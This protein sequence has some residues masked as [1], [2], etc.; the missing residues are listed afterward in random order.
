M[1]EAERLAA[2]IRTEAARLRGVLAEFQIAAAAVTPPRSLRNFSDELAALGETSKRFRSALIALP[3]PDA[4]TRQAML[5]ARDEYDAVASQ[6]LT[7]AEKMMAAARAAR[8][9][10]RWSLKN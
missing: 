8:R 3:E 9:K 6:I 5:A 1:T 7:A 2:E 10:R 4:P